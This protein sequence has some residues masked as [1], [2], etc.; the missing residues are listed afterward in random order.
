[1]VEV[2]YSTAEE[3]RKWDKAEIAARTQVQIAD[4]LWDTN[5][6][7][8]SGYLKDAWA[9]TARVEEPK[10]VR[11]NFMNSS[12][13]NA[14]RREVLLVARKRAPELARKWLG[15]IAQE[16]KSSEDEER[17]TFDDRTTRSS[18]LLQMANEIVADNP[19]A[20][21][22][23]AIDSLRDG[24]S[25]NLQTVLIRIQQK[26]PSLAETVLRAA[27]KRLSTVGMS[28]PNELLVIYAYLYTPGRIYGTNGTDN[29]TSFPMVVG[30]P[31]VSVPPASQNPA[32]ALEFLDI[33][34]DSLLNAPL[35]SSSASPKMSARAQL[36]VIGWLLGKLWQLLPEKAALLQ[37]R[38][39]Q[40][41][42]DARFS[43]TP[44]EPRPDVPELLPGETS[45][46][47][48]ARRVDILEEAAAKGKDVLTRDIA[49]AKAAVMTTVDSYERGLSLSGKI[50]DKDL[51]NGIRSWVVYRAVLHL[52]I[53]GK[54]DEAY[55][56]NAKNDDPAQRAA[57]LVVGAQQLV[58]DKD[59]VRASE[60]LREA[61]L[62]AG[63]NEPNE[64]WT[65]IVLGVVSTYGSF[66]G[67]ASLDWLREAVKLMKKAPLASLTDERAP[68]IKRLIGIA[69]LSDFTSSTKGFSL[70]AAVAT[71]GPEQFE[72]ALYILDD[73]TPRE[74]RGMAVVTLCRN[75]L[76]V[77]PKAPKKGS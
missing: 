59:I 40:L 7:M 46:N 9:T 70:P 65:R 45:E 50:D 4:L 29:R 58:K 18:V 39:Q 41:D 64:A 57:G 13:R 62:M 34:S 22:E 43:N 23:L 52:L 33:A 24:I 32:L 42:S 73:I 69:P 67:E 35:A 61:G 16:S 71:F 3:A 20:A 55:K 77:K 8:A 15:E 76:H 56:L 53:S 38:A 44:I 31:R 74:A 75:F 10:R 30:G 2:L 19:Q 68:L 1:V 25:F 28:D 6:E 47:Y 26:N 5:N 66:D 63:K 49:Y 36:S 14:V 48:A 37:A 11:S 54:L 17:G 21:A 12:R 27:L 51:R 72:R 60:W